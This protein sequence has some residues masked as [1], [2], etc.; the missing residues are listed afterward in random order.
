[1]LLTMLAETFI[2]S[3][4]FSSGI[5]LIILERVGI[6]MGRSLL[7]FFLI[8]YF[9]SSISASA[10]PSP[11]PLT[12]SSSFYFLGEIEFSSSSSSLTVESFFTSLFLSFFSS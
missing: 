11:S 7:S 1:M 5:R 4:I 12:S 2:D 9:F 3:N 8:S 10:S 6:G